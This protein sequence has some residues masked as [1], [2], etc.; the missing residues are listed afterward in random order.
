MMQQ[1]GQVNAIV[2]GKK[3]KQNQL[4]NITKK[5]KKNW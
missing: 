5:K 3:V 1:T 4:T 2:N